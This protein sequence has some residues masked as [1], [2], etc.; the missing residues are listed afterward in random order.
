MLLL[1]LLLILIVV[2]ITCPI[3]PSLNLAITIA[4]WVCLILYCLGFVGILGSGP[5]VRV[6]R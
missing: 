1:T 4:L 3:P 2:K 6:L 5:Y